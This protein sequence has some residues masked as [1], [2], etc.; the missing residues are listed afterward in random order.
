MNNSNG[1][2]T[3]GF[4]HVKQLTFLA[5]LIDYS[6]KLI[7][8][9]DRPQ[10]DPH[11]IMSDSIDMRGWEPW[12]QKY[13]YGVLLIIPPEPSLSLVDSLRV[14]YAWAQSSECPAHISLTVP[15]PQ[16]LAPE[17]WTELVGIAS[18]IK[19][20]TI[21]YGPLTHYLPHPG[22]VLRIDPQDRLD[23]LREAL[24][25]ASCFAQADPR[26]YPFSAHMTIAEMISA[27][28]TIEIMSALQGDAPQGSFLCQKVSHVVP[29]DRFR[30]AE[31]TRLTLGA[32]DQTDTMI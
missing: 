9:Q 22:V 4:C 23:H 24:E 17:H 1:I 2:L 7:T 13:R 3:T 18:E 32:T 12:Q 29:D 5:Y 30:F 28:Q 31:R 11:E 10:E 25:S 20:F 27:E 14:R 19:P 26:R 15:L 16:P 21:H 6:S 8:Q